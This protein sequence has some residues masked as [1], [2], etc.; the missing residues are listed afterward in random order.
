MRKTNKH[1]NDSWDR[2]FYETGST[3]PPKQNGGLIA[4]LLVL[5]VLLGSICSAMGILNI[6]LLKRLAEGEQQHETL[7]LFAVQYLFPHGRT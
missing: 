7:N 2:D 3:R 6:H 4:F 1:Y 5:V